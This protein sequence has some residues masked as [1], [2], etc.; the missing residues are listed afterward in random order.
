ML[1]LLHLTITQH[2]TPPAFFVGGGSNGVRP[3]GGVGL[4]REEG[5]IL[6]PDADGNSA[7]LAF[8]M[9]QRRQREIHGAV[10]N[11]MG[12]GGSSSNRRSRRRPANGG[13]EDDAALAAA[14]AE[15]ACEL[16]TL[17]NAG[18]RSCC[19]AC[20]SARPPVPRSPRNHDAARRS[21]SPVPAGAGP[22]ILLVPGGGIG[23]MDGDGGQ[24]EEGEE[25]L[26]PPVLPGGEEGKEEETEEAKAADPNV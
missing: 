13:G 2:R 7:Q 3:H 19:E 12:G 22:P 5:V 9:T 4:T 15:W 17:I 8:G 16:C 21:P 20:G 6:E 10:V 25:A 23:G 26:L 1:A 18:R 11:M 24:G 14:A